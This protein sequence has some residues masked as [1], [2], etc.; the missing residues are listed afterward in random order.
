MNNDLYEIHRCQVR[1]SGDMMLS[2]PAGLV[3]LINAQPNH[4]IPPISFRIRNYQNLENVVPN[5]QVLNMWVSVANLYYIIDPSNPLFL[6]CHQGTR[7]DERRTSVP[8]QH[9]TVNFASQTA[10][11]TKSFG[12]LLQCGYP[13]GTQARKRRHT[14]LAAISIDPFYFLNICVIDISLFFFS[15]LEMI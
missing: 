11:R 13:Q 4:N 8:F 2:F 9:A 6:A 15:P 1:I 12:V 10:S 3:Q 5:K 14:L 7:S